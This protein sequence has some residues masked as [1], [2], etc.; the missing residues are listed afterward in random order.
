MK[1]LL[2]VVLEYIEENR[3]QGSVLFVLLFAVL[4]CLLVP[5]SFMTM[6]AGVI[7]HP[8]IVAI[9]LVLLGSQLGLLI[10]I[11][12]GRTVLR[13]WVES[14]IKSDA[15]LAAIDRVINKEG[16]KIVILLRLSPI[17]PFGLAN[18]ILS[19]TSISL[20]LL[21]GATFIGNLPGAVAGAVV[22]SFVGSLTGAGDYKVSPRAQ[23]LGLLFSGAVGAVS[24]VYVGLVARKALR[25]AMLDD[26]AQ[27]TPGGAAPLLGPPVAN[28]ANADLDSAAA[29]TAALLLGATSSADGVE[30]SAALSGASYSGRRRGSPAG[31]ASSVDL[32]DPDVEAAFMPDARARRPRPPQPVAGESDLMAA[33]GPGAAAASGFSPEE[34]RTLRMTVLASFAAVSTG[35]PVAEKLEVDYEI[36]EVIR[37]KIIP[38]AV[39]WFTGKALEFEDFGDDDDDDEEGG[40]SLDDVDDEDGEEGEEGE[41]A[42]ECKQQ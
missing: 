19:A 22:G 37:E 41:K 30:E 1:A 14:R 15:T 40:F 17:A 13:P 5:I 23:Y 33:I 6:A 12:L 18:Y 29:D 26:S 27:A 36:G 42:P 20:P 39:H 21:A 7:F 28:N 2:L 10:S 16:T 9:A 24:I 35:V 8:V 34:R 31:R 11:L 4:S 32:L 25:D 38:A 3:A